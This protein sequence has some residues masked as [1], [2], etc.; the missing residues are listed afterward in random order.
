MFQVLSE[1]SLQSWGWRIPFLMAGPLGLIGRY[2][3]VHLEDLPKYR[4]MAEKTAGST[5]KSVPLRVL[6][7]DHRRSLAIAF[8]VASLNAVA[9]YL[10]LS[11]MPT[12]LSAELGIDE[13]TA[14]L[15]S[16][17]A[18][19]IYIGSIFVMG[20]I[21]DRFG[22]GGCWCVAILFTV[23]RCRCSPCSAQAGSG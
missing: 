13:G 23:L 11:Y 20:H 5:K 10:L 4:A 17:V 16:T 7:A 21:S 22:R 14:F 18:L 8:G 2:I 3:R 12:Y 1:D 19:T 6:F 15:A 9:F